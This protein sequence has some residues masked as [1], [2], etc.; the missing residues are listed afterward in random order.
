MNNSA[1]NR[2]YDQLFCIF[3]FTYQVFFFIYD[4]YK[5]SYDLFLLIKPGKIDFDYT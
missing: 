4:A 2:S 5:Q 3:N 1:E